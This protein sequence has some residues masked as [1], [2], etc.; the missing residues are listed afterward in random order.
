MVFESEFAFRHLWKKNHGYMVCCETVASKNS[1]MNTFIKRHTQMV[2]SRLFLLEYKC[3]R[4]FW[5][6]K[7]YDTSF[8]WLQ[9]C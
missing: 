2:S 6:T 9:I 3:V 5:K 4:I 7:G 8:F 1:S